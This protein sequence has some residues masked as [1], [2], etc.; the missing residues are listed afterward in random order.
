MAQRNRPKN[1]R[2]LLATVTGEPFQLVRL[3]WS[4]PTSTAVTQAFTALR[5]MDEDDKARCWVWLYDGEAAALTFGKPRSALPPEV[6]PI[7]IGRFRLLQNRLVLELRSFE[8]AVEA[9]K[10]FAPL[11]GPKVVLT[12]ARVINRWFEAQEA[13][14][15]LDVLD[16][17]LD[18]DVVV[19]DPQQSDD[20][21]ERTLQG[22]RTQ[23]EKMRAFARFSQERKKQDVPLVEDFP[24]VPE[25]ETADFRHLTMT[26]ELRALRAFEH[27][28][29][30][31]EL[32]LADVIHRLVEQGLAGKK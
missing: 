2:I 6:H 26:L 16:R 4:I 22:A 25:E 21:L 17:L 24:L 10:F 5:C 3:Y 27:W 13:K 19:V 7:A 14:G 32:T 30:H 15:G 11:F 8:R 31:T 28:N 1:D 29:G 23:A 12:R 20:A 9:A 18:Q